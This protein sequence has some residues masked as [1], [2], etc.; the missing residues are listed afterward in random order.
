CALLSH[1]VPRVESLH[2]DGELVRREALVPVH[3][4][5]RATTDARVALDD[6]VAREEALLRADRPAPRDHLRVRATPVEEEETEVREWVA[7]RRHLPVEDGDDLAGVVGR[8]SRGVGA[9]LAAA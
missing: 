4:V 8:D 1:L 9:A 6:L 5:D 3:L 2:D 7:E